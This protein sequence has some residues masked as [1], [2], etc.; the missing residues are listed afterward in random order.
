VIPHASLKESN[1]WYIGVRCYSACNFKLLAQLKT[2]IEIEDTKEY[3]LQFGTED[4]NL[5]KMWVPAAEER[6]GG[7]GVSA[8]TIESGAVMQSREGE[9]GML[10][11][12]VTRNRR[13]TSAGKRAV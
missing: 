7:S 3:Q 13:A 1:Q 12:A 9:D 8:V 4:T 2:P 5:F 11:T 10:M 6:D